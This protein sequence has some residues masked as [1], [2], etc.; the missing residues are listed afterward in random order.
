VSAVVVGFLALWVPSSGWS[1]G[2]SW[3]PPVSREVS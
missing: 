2:T 3:F 1:F